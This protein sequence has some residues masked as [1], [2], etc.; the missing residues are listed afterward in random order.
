MFIVIRNTKVPQSTQLMKRAMMNNLNH[1]QLQIFVTKGNRSR[2]MI[3]VY[4]KSGPTLDWTK[5]VLL[6]AYLSVFYCAAEMPCNGCSIK[7][8][9]LWMNLHNGKQHNL[10]VFE[11]C[12]F[13]SLLGNWKLYVDYDIH[14]KQLSSTTIYCTHRSISFIF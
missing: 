2:P 10:S 1:F 5:C 12:G 8:I 14:M 11:F 4:V 7:E 9:Q 13:H 3:R 6:L